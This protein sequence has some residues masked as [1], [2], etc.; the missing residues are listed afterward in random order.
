MGR[1]HKRAL[2]QG[3]HPG[4]GPLRCPKEDQQT[5]RP[6]YIQLADVKLDLLVGP[7]TTGEGAVPDSVAC[8]WILFSL[9]G[10]PCL[11]S[12]GKNVIGSAVMYVPRWVGMGW[13]GSFPFS[14]EVWL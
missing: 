11:A 5:Q 12:M 2:L 14:E 8:L 10:L 7:P 4:Q 9:T 13:G 3:E 1:D 6:S